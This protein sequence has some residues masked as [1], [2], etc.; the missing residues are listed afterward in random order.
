LALFCFVALAGAMPALSLASRAPSAQTGRHSAERRA[1]GAG[2]SANIVVTFAGSGA[3]GYRYRV[4]AAGA[5]L[6]A[7]S[8]PTPAVSYSEHDSYSWRFTF[9]VPA[10]G[11]VLDGPSRSLGGGLL[12]GSTSQCAGSATT[13]TSCSQQ[14][15]APTP[16][17]NDDLGYPAVSV[18]VTR[19]HLTIGVIGELV[20][21]APAASCANGGSYQ[22]NP[23]AGFT[24]LQ[25]NVTIQR[26]ALE[27]DG[28]V[29]V[30]FTMADSGLFAGVALSG[31]C[32]ALTCQP[33]SCQSAGA[34]PGG[35]GADCSYYEGY[36]GAVE[37]RVAK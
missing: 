32:D 33:L 36:A 15:G 21:S 8:C 11:A 28:H 16:L 31:G 14:L 2:S 7:V 24:Q 27:R 34:A 10:A 35:R 1:L 4:P 29:S 18:T 17:D 13:V 30:P 12:S 26:A 37:V 22:P 9:I 6:F 20:P 23:L 19:S 5:G 25:A 3:G